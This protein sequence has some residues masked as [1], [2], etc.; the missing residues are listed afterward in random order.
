MGKAHR[1]A[2]TDHVRTRLRESWDNRQNERKAKMDDDKL[3]ETFARMWM[4]CDPNR[5][6]SDPDEIMHFDAGADGTVSTLSGQPRW[7]W[8]MPR[9]EAS[10]KFLRENGVT[11]RPRP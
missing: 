8:F 1:I 5:G 11:V 7:K 6:G 10:L 3:I 2:K 9:A 4:Q